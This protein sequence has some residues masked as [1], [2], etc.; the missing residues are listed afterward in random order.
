MNN[1]STDSVVTLKVSTNGQAKVFCGEICDN[2]QLSIPSKIYIDNKPKTIQSTYIYNL[3]PENVVKLVWEN[4]IIECRYMF[5]DCSSIVEINFISFDTSKCEDMMGMFRD[6][7]SLISL[8]LSCFDTSKV[9]RISDMFWNCF[10]IKSLNILSFDTSNVINGMG[11]MFCN[12]SSLKSLNI[13]NFKTSKVAYIDNM[14]IGCTNLTSIDLSNFITSNTIWMEGM[15][16]GCISLTSVDISHFDTSLVTD[17][18]N[19]FYNCKLLTSINISNFDLSS[20]E[21]IDNIFNG[22]SSLKYLYF[23]NFK[24]TNIISMDNMFLDNIN[25]EYVNIKNYQPSNNVETYYFFNNCPKNLV[26]CTENAALKNI[27]ESHDCNTVNCLD[28][29]YDYRKKINIE[30]GQCVDNC[31]LINYKYEYNYKC[32]LNCLSGTYNN[33]YKCEDC[34]PDCKECNGPYTLDNTHCISCSSPDK[35]LKFGNCVNKNECLR[36]I[37]YNET[38]K[39]VICKCDLEQCF[40]CSFDSFRQNLCIQCETSNGYYPIFDDKYNPY[41]NCS[42]S[43]EG[44]YLDNKDYA[45]KLCFSS[46]KNCEKPG[47]EISHNCKECKYG[48]NYE[49]H[50]EIYKNC[51]IDCSFYHYYNDNISFCTKSQECPDEFNKLIEDKRECVSNCKKDNYYKYEFR[52]HCFKECPYNSTLR[53]NIKELEGFNIDKK[54]FCKPICNEESPF[55]ILYTQVCVKN[56]DINSIIDKTCILNLEGLKTE[57]EEEKNAKAYEIMFKN[58]ELGFTSEEYD[59]LHLE[60]GTDDIIEYEKMKIILTTTNNERSNVNNPN[61]TAIDLGQCELILRENYNISDNDLLFMIKVE[62]IQEGMKIP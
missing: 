46:C 41:L 19:L 13:S 10:S 7:H 16:S 53:K 31:I 50:F 14:F 30:N 8:D 25:L 45:Y 36:D 39:Q 42:K 59:S 37:Y 28:N 27:I 1:L 52:K 54:Y 20:V 57:N 11:H 23:S 48:Y 26:V 49:L 12:C 5:R 62:L 38:T 51:Y 61:E 32:Y 17:M 18:S 47:N 6:C 3:N 35:V 44:Y 21:N 43:P 60:N 15:F 2:V 33:N 34:H 56:C 58:I 9:T 24:A 22:C 40:T 55:E 29:W 4:D